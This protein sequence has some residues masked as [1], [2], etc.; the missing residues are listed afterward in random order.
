MV[1]P[2][3]IHLHLG[4]LKR[5]SLVLKSKRLKKVRINRLLLIEPEDS[6]P[7]YEAWLEG[8]MAGL[9]L[10][11]ILALKESSARKIPDL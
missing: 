11:V 6:S 2:C 8:G 7:L 3:P 1:D 5:S 4:I 10:I 9:P